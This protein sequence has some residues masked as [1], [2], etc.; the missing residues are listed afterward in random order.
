M[1]ITDIL[2]NRIVRATVATGAYIAGC[3][4]AYNLGKELANKPVVYQGA[5]L[6]KKE[7]YAGLKRNSDAIRKL[8]KGY[9]EQ[10]IDLMFDAMMSA[11]NDNLSYLSLLTDDAELKTDIEILAAKTRYRLN[12]LEKGIKR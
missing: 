1:I 5:H 7:V 8:Q 4:A 2:G 11:N 3:R 12:E 10:D 6:D 9:E